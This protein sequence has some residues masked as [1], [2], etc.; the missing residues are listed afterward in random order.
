MR[1]ENSAKINSEKLIPAGAPEKIESKKENI[2]SDNDAIISILNKILASFQ[3]DNERMRRSIRDAA[4]KKLESDP[5]PDTPGAP[6]K[7]GDDKKSGMN[8]LLMLG[9]IAGLLIAAYKFKDEIADLIL[10]TKTLSELGFK[11]STGEVVWNQEKDKLSDQGVLLIYS[12]N[13]KDGVLDV[14]SPLKDPKKQYI[15]GFKRPPLSGKVILINRGYG[16]ASYSL[17][18]VLFESNQFYA[19]N[20]VN[21]VRPVTKNAEKIIDSV[22]RSLLS[23]NTSRFIEYF[24]GNNALS[25]SEIES[26]LP[27]WLD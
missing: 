11:V 26:C 15:Q 23:D 17:K 4:E 22:Y 20:H 18:C 12:S 6:V 24:V 13:F 25:K 19:E 16:N 10:N 3:S 8:K 27:I 9:A 5:T 1:A 2:S 7:E 21:V 14:E